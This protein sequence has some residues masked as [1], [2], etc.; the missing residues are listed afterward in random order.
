ML[1][2]ILNDIREI[3]LRTA[4]GRVATALVFSANHGGLCRRQGWFDAR[5]YRHQIPWPLRAWPLTHFLLYGWRDGKTPVEGYD[6]TRAVA[7]YPYSAS[8]MQ[9]PLEAYVL[10]GRFIGRE[11]L[12][13]DRTPMDPIR[14]APP[15]AAADAALVVHAHYREELAAIA[16]KIAGMRLRCDLYVTTSHQDAWVERCLG[17]HGVTPVQVIRGPNRGRD[18]A[19]FVALLAAGLAERYPLIGKVHTKRSGHVDRGAAWFAASIESLLSDRTLAR[20]RDCADPPLG[21]LA[22]T[23]QLGGDIT[24]I[25]N[26]DRLAWL[27]ARA[28][29]GMPDSLTF[30]HGSMFW[31]QSAALAPLTRLGL[32]MEDFEAEAGQLDGTLAHALERFIGACCIQQGWAMAEAAPK[33]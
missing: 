15:D 4:I 14:L 24:G 7:G 18:F 1:T 28:G 11:F 31:V 2:R 32:S 33:R 22:A 25:T 20:L 10:V 9:T 26:R 19:P 5:Q 17:D 8:T 29:L 3:G 30:P 16:H 13:P 23:G 21:L 27:C 12:A 6:N